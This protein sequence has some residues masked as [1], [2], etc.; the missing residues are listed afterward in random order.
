MD[1]KLEKVSQAGNIEVFRVTCGG[2]V[3]YG[4]STYIPDED[5]YMHQ[6]SCA[7]GLLLCRIFDREAI[8]RDHT[9][10]AILPAPTAEDLLRNKPVFVS[11]AAQS[12]GASCDMTG[13]ELVELFS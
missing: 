5:A 13:A 8:E 2:A 3:A 9:V 11:T 4:A 10:A 1:H 7:H 6:I 12:M